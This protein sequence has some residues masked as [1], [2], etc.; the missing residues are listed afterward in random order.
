[1]KKHPRERTA[2]HE[3]GHIVAAIEKGIR[4][5]YATIVPTKTRKGYV[6]PVGRLVPKDPD[7]QRTFVEKEIIFLLAGPAAEQMLVGRESIGDKLDDVRV[8]EFLACLHSDPQVRK[9][10]LIYLMK[11]VGQILVHDWDLVTALAQALMSR[12]VLTG[13]EIDK[14][15]VDCGWDIPAGQ[16]SDNDEERNGALQTFLAEGESDPAKAFVDGWN[17][18]RFLKWSQL[19]DV[20]PR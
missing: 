18:A 9:A 7:L 12:G 15:V 19:G 1:M 11:L 5:S 14:L 6:Q 4:I 10:Y 17:S 16:D 8:E 20:N 13:D 2:Y 3:A